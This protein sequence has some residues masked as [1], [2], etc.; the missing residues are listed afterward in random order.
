MV[1]AEAPAGHQLGLDIT[2]VWKHKASPNAAVLSVQHFFARG[3]R[4]NPR[5]SHKR[6]QLG[7][8]LARRPR[9]G[10]ERPRPHCRQTRVAD[11]VAE[12]TCLLARFRASPPW[13][14]SY[15]PAPPVT[16]RNG[17]L[18]S[19]R[20][21]ATWTGARGQRLLTC[22]VAVLSTRLLGP[23]VGGQL[24]Q[25]HL[26]F[27]D[28]ISVPWTLGPCPRPSDT[29]CVCPPPSDTVCVPVPQTLGPCPCPSDI[30][31]M[32]PH[33]LDTV[34]VPIPQ[35]LGLCPC[36]SDIKCMC[37]HSLDTVCVPVP[38]TLGVCPCPMDTKCVCPHPLDTVCVPVPRTLG[39]CPHPSDTRSVSPSLGH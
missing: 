21:G 1:T 22:S 26:L 19:D 16:S 18:D 8:G 38:Q 3:N 2:Q 35:T 7:G 31:C 23:E 39:L 27:T 9:G 11:L 10:P 14:C 36:P 32:C 33:S 5:R 15:V 6:W 25:D 13:C 20:T 30:K 29:R 37:P 28:T 34:C 12:D 24:P 4:H 17:S